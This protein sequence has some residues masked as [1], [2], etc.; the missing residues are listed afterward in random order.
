MDST[1]TKIKNAGKLMMRSW[2]IK[3]TCIIL[4][5]IEFELLRAG[6]VQGGKYWKDNE[7][8]ILIIS[9]VNLLLLMYSFLIEFEIAKIFQSVEE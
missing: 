9:I 5:I 6:L 4:I 1:N 2:K 8:F 7:P 3:L